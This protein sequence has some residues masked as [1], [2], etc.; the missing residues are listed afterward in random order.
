MKI[1]DLLNKICIII[2]SKFRDK[3][4]LSV[5]NWYTKR[6]ELCDGCDDNSKYHKDKIKKSIKERAIWLANNKKDYCMLCKCGIA[7]KA[8]EELEECSNKENKKWE[9]IQ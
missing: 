7:D 1:T 5:N 3:E 4:K 9:S 6:L 2:K 8:S